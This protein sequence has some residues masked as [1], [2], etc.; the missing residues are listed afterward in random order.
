M[1]GELVLASGNRGK[2]REFDELLRP[3]GIVVRPQG[4]WQVPEAVED[5]PTFIENALIKARQA[6][7]FTG[8]PSLADDSGLV[9]PVLG[10]QPGIYSA[11]YS[12]EGA[13]AQANMEKLLG[14]LKEH[15]GAARD[16]WFYCA[17]VLVKSLDDPAPLVATGQWH[18]RILKTARGEGGF[19]YDPVFGVSSLKDYRQPYSAA[20]LEAETKSRVSH[21][22]QALRELVRKLSEQDAGSSD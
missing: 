5:A 14:E 12:G 20:E 9:V 19:G 7:R 10:G 22:G 21:R 8:L 17:L 1:K 16:A 15:H 18:G 3:M 11:R 6:V 2:L 13:D 4:D